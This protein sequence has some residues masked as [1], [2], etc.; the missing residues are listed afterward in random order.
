[1]GLSVAD[2]DAWELNEAFAAQSLAV[3]RTLG[4]DPTRVNVNGGAIALGH[5][6]GCSGAKILTTLLNVLERQGGRYGV[7]TLCV[8]VGQGVATLIER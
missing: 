2:I 1:M 6:L 4:I 5:P 3:I 8:G 7:A